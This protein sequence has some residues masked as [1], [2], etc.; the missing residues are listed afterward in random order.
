MGSWDIKK[1]NKDDGYLANGE[2]GL[3]VDTPKINK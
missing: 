2:I 3:L 1:R